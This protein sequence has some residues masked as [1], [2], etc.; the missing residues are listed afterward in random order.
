M[1]AFVEIGNFKIVRGWQRKWYAVLNIYI[2]LLSGVEE[3]LS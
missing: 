2:N 3:G 1:V